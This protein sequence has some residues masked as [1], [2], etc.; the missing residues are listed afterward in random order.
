MK[1]LNTG[2]TLIELM[3]VVAIIGVLAAIALPAYQ[4]Y[5][6]R[7][8]VSEGLILASAAE[9]LVTENAVNS[10]TALNA[11]WSPLTGPTNN[12]LAIDVDA[13]TGVISVT[14][15]SKAAGVALQLTPSSGGQP[16][17]G[18]TSPSGSVAWRCTTQP[19]HFVNVPANCRQTS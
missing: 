13:V 19:E 18:G 2:F 4:S 15:T 11:S 1:R 14:Y 6:V 5:L 9:L 7:A 8:R 10:V 17:T 16:L 3:I 12:V